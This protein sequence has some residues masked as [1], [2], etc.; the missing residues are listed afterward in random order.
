M[1]MELDHDIVLEK[2]L[3]QRQKYL[4]KFL[5]KHRRETDGWWQ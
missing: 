1:A 4:A 2:T 3:N 5:Q